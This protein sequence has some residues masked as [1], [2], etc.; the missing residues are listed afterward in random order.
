[1]GRNGTP[2]MDGNTRE[3]LFLWMAS[4]SPGVP[5]PDEF[6]IQHHGCTQVG[7]LERVVQRD[8]RPVGSSGPPQGHTSSHKTE[9]ATVMDVS[10]QATLGLWHP[11]LT[12]DDH[13]DKE[14]AQESPHR[15]LSVEGDSALGSC[16]AT[17]EWS[18]LCPVIPLSPRCGS[19]KISLSQP[20]SQ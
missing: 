14:I 7:A 10:C 1:M 18:C 20:P 17:L 11:L 2:G 6:K 16:R 8:R 3:T 5:C 13:S 12:G 9:M 4:P 19:C 15:K